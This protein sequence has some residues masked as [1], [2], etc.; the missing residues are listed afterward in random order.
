MRK[1]SQLRGRR[2]GIFLKYGKIADCA[3]RHFTNSVP[4]V[5][6]VVVEVL[7]PL[8]KLKEE[9]VEREKI[10][11]IKVNYISLSAESGHFR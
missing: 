8:H 10:V 7:Y 2:S 6:L 9:Y 4:E 5:L 11:N 3:T 1:K